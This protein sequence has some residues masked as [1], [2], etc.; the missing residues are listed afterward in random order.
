VE[1]ELDG[2]SV[3]CASKEISKGGS[4]VGDNVVAGPDSNE[5]GNESVA[6]SDAENLSG[7]GIAQCRDDVVFFVVAVS[8]L[9]VKACGSKLLSISCPVVRKLASTSGGEGFLSLPKRRKLYSG[10]KGI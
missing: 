2:G 6:A 7:E 4:A 8:P 3:S 1:K 10:W 5:G 9:R